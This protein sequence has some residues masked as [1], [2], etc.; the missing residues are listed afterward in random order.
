MYGENGENGNKTEIKHWD[1]AWEIPIK[2]R[3]PSRLNV[4]VNN[5]LR[6]IK[7]NVLPGCR[8]L[9]IGCA[10]GKLLA[11]VASVL[12]ADV[13]G[14]DYSEKGIAQCRFLF[15]TLGLKVN[16]YNEDLFNHHINKGYYDVVTSFG[17]IEHFNDA[18]LVVKKHLDFVRPGGLALITI[19]NYSR[20]YGTMQRWCD[21]PN[22]LLHNL[23]IMNPAAL[24][25]LVD[26]MKV[27]SIRAYPFGMVSP[28][29]IS[30]EKRFPRYIASMAS[31]GINFLGLIQ[32]LTIKSLAP[33]LVLEIRKGSSV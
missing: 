8:Y 17:V 26:S 12:K 10:P 22:L 14:I 21:A 30:F 18:R 7:K 13:S 4:G 24:T 32:P 33:L 3:L 1:A 28:W 9:E 2:Q 16:L 31:Y 25:A 20:I 19:P 27:E 11:W 23:E 5:I 15:D 29:I 6:L